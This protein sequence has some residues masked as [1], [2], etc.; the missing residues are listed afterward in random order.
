MT[1]IIRSGY[2]RKDGVIVKPTFVCTK[3]LIGPLKKGTLT[4]FGY[5]LEQTAAVRRQSV[6]KAV[7]KYGAL[8]IFRKLNAVAT[9]QKNS[10]PENSKKFKADATWLKKEY[11]L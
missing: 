2:I 3:T 8:A 6:K 1:C 11:L 5:S 10:S 9:L 7:K 4:Q